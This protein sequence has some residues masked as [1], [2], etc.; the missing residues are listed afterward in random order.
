MQGVLSYSTSYTETPAIFVLSAGTNSNRTFTE[1]CPIKFLSSCDQI[2]HWVLHL[3]QRT[4]FVHV[5]MKDNSR[6]GRGFL[7]GFNIYKIT[8]TDAKKCAFKVLEALTES[9]GQ[10]PK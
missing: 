5:N 2:S 8:G 4:I 9:T 1:S 10:W 3:K 6:N 7:A